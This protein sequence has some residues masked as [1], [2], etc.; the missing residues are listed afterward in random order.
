MPIDP[1]ALERAMSNISRGELKDPDSLPRKC[2]YCDEEM[3]LVEVE[4]GASIILEWSSDRGKF[5]RSPVR[6]ISDRSWKMACLNEQ[7]P[8]YPYAYDVDVSNLLLGGEF[9]TEEVAS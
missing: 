7:C 5:F 3:F 6:R 8:K 9:E 1:E 2:P 4:K